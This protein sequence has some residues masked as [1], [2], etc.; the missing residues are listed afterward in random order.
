MFSLGSVQLLMQSISL[1][2][3]GVTVKEDGSFIPVTEYISRAAAEGHILGPWDWT[4][5]ETGLTLEGW[6][7]FVAVEEEKDKG[8]PTMIAMM[9]D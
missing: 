9:M 5:D 6:E 3:T 1:V 8:Q 2:S 7:I 4:D